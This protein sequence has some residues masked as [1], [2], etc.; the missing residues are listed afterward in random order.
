MVEGAGAAGNNPNAGKVGAPKDKWSNLS[1]RYKSTSVKFE[2]LQPVTINNET[3]VQGTALIRGK[4]L[5]EFNE[6]KKALEAKGYKFESLDNQGRGDGQ[7]GWIAMVDCQ[8]PEKMGAEYVH[9]KAKTEPKKASSAA[10]S[11]PKAE[12][13]SATDK[14]IAGYDAQ[15]VSFGGILGFGA[16]KVNVHVGKI[17]ENKLTV[18]GSKTGQASSSFEIAGVVEF[19]LP[20]GS[21][22][23]DAMEVK[24]ELEKR[25]YIFRP[26]QDGSDYEV[27]TDKSTGKIMFRNQ[28]V[29]PQ[30]AQQNWGGEVARSIQE[31]SGLR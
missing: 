24:Q 29:L 5:A 26:M 19:E 17:H 6:A 23:Q 1:V 15:P 11:N 21:S 28:A 25:G 27:W 30:K 13:P 3:F 12:L 14:C 9:D 4:N 7:G 2:N 31:G 22:I 18:T 8:L 10:T 16:T 20:A